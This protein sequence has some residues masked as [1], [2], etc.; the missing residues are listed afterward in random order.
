M[1]IRRNPPESA[2]S[3]RDP[4]KSRRTSTGIHRNPP[5]ST[6]DSPTF[7]RKSA[8]IHRNSP[9]FTGIRRNPPDLAAP[10]PQ[11]H[12]NPLKSGRIR[13]KPETALPNSVEFQSDFSPKSGPES[14]G[15]FWSPNIIQNPTEIRL[16]F[17]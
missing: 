15:S 11:I 2:E 10:R 7:S 13:W 9:E 5:K 8:E 17:N 6:E 12:R 4:A 16:K 1:Q 3:S 14:A